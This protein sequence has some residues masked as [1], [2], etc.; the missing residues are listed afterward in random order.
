[1]TTSNSPT[2]T[3]REALIAFLTIGAIA[4]HLILRYGFGVSELAR[5][6]PLFIVVSNTVV[7]FP[8]EIWPVDG[9]VAEGQG[10]MALSI[11]GMSVPA[12]GHLPPV[13][14]AVGQE[15]IDVLAVAN[16]LRVAIVPRSL[17][18]FELSSR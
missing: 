11:L 4:A 7:V 9:T 14:G 1:M 16:A 15:I 3:R 12:A 5:N 6:V 18:D 8:H 13:A 10:G 2:S 17:V